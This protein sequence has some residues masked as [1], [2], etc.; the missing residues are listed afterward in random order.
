MTRAL[1]IAVVTVGIVAAAAAAPRKKKHEPGLLVIVIDRSGTMQGDKLEAAKKA[2]KMAIDAL[3]PT[4]DVAVVAFDSTAE[5]YLRPQFA[6]TVR[7]HYIDRLQ[8]GGGTNFADALETTR[9]LFLDTT[10]VHKHVLF[11]SDGQAAPTFRLE[12]L[13]DH[14]AEDGITISTVGI[15][16]DADPALLGFIADHGHGRRYMFYDLKV[17]PWVFDN[18]VRQAIPR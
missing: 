17:Q 1:A 13:V 8:A 10:A 3:D 6:S 5:I 16:D 4:D 18:E 2:T 12:H 9:E 15:G 11:L 14:M 7:M